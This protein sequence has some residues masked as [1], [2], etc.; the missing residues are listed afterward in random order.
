MA[1]DLD[2]PELG[3]EDPQLAA[4]IEKARGNAARFPVL[5]AA[6]LASIAARAEGHGACA[7]FEA[8]PGGLLVCPCGVAFQV[9]KPV[10]GSEAAA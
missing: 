2:P 9:G 4:L 3:N 5:L 6:A 8:R 1:P 7:G 10:T